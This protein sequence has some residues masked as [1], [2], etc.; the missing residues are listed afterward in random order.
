MWSR[1]LLPFFRYAGALHCVRPVSITASRSYT[2]LFDTKQSLCGRQDIRYTVQRTYRRIVD[3]GKTLR[4][5]EWAATNLTQVQKDF[6]KPHEQTI[7]R[8]DDEVDAY[9]R[10]QRI[11]VSGD[12]PKPILSFD[13]L[14]VG[15]FMANQIKQHQ[16]KTVSPVQAQGWPIALSGL[17]MVGIAQTG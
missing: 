13:E 5:P 4:T 17:N 10:E 1:S 16:F 14:C 9:R 6:Y 11:S 12:V 7:N 2:V 15:D 3:A 8:P